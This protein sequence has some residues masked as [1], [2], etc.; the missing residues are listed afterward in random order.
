MCAAGGNDVRASL[1]MMLTYGQM[2]LCLSAQMKKSNS[3]ELDFLV[4]ELGFEPRQ[5]ESESAV[6]PLHN[7]ALFTTR[8]DC[9]KPYWCERRDLNPY[10]VTTR[11]LNVRV[12]RF[13]HSRISVRNVYI[14][15][16]GISFVKSFFC[17]FSMYFFK[18]PSLTSFFPYGIMQTTE[19]RCKPWIKNKRKD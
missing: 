11:T 10:G 1:E 15:A 8:N 5:T 2:M 19:R 6:L 3:Q 17:I 7:S 16:E 12:C 9:R 18:K 13:R 4:A 14:I